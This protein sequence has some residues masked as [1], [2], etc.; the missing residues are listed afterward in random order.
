LGEG[1]D[2]RIGGVNVVVRGANGIKCNKAEIGI[3]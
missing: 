3:E 1:E 2:W